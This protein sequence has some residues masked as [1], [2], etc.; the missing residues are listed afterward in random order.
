MSQARS[1]CQNVSMSQSK[2]SVLCGVWCGSI[3]RVVWPLLTLRLLT[4]DT[5]PGTVL[6]HGIST[7]NVGV[8]TYF[9]VDDFVKPPL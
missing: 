3:P 1:V 8:S 2:M 5:Y 4:L 7:K 9:Q 6:Y